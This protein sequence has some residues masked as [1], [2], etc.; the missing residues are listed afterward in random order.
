[1][2]INIILQYFRK[3]TLFPLFIFI[4]QYPCL[5]QTKISQSD[6]DLALHFFMQG[7]FLIKQGNYAAAVL[8]LQEAIDLDPNVP[9]I[10][11]SIADAYIRLGKNRRAENH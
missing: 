5:A 6:K 8:E 9:T 1:M 4:V 11:V 10:H 2:K 7:E 3:I